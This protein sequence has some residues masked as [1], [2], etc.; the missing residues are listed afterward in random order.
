[1]TNY[2]VILDSQKA[3]I[4]V[5]GRDFVALKFNFWPCNCG[6]GLIFTQSYSPYTSGWTGDFLDLADI[7]AGPAMMLPPI[8]VPII[9]FLGVEVTNILVG[10]G[11]PWKR[12]S[13]WGTESLGFNISLLADGFSRV[14]TLDRLPKNALTVIGLSRVDMELKM[15]PF[16][17]PISVVYEVNRTKLE[18][19][20]GLL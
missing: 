3:S 18:L 10:S 8:P 19:K 14:L 12:V 13:V 7:V 1:M 11:V 6:M 4:V 15:I 20:K 16:S 5:S 9:L 2:F 17:A